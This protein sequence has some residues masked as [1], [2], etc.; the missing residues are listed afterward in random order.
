MVEMPFTHSLGLIAVV[1]MGAI[2]ARNLAKES[3]VRRMPR[4]L[5]YTLVS[6]LLLAM[7]G[8]SLTLF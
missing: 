1:L 8:A 6:G 3:A 7:L 2:I 4:G 5:R